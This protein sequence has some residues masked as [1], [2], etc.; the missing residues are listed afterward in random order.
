MASK[1]G[2]YGFDFEGEYIEVEPPHRYTYQ[3]G[4]RQAE[5]LFRPT[6]DGTSTEVIV[7]FEPETTHPVDM[8]RDGWQAILNNFKAYVETISQS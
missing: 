2:Q 6:N 5:V 3:F 8:Q 7:S 1:D 4:E